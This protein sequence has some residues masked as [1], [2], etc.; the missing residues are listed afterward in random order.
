MNNG[1][2]PL[3]IA[4]AMMATLSQNDI[5]GSTGTGNRKKLIPN[6][7]GLNQR[8]TRKNKRRAF[9]NGFKNAHLK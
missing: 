8:Q 1:I 3:T 7:I 2:L 6:R 9:A 5:F 4:S